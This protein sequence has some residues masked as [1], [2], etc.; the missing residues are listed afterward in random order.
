MGGFR[1]GETHAPAEVQIPTFRAASGRKPAKLQIENTGQEEASSPDYRRYQARSPAGQYTVSIKGFDVGDNTCACPDFKTNTLGTC[2]HIEAVL[3]HL[4]MTLL[5][6]ISRRRKA[7]VTR[8]EI[9]LHYGEQICSSKFTCPL[10]HSDKL[11][12]LA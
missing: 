8:P 11:A 2:K 1:E 6:R 4:K 3:D 9:A 7:V 12:K 10:R 5:R